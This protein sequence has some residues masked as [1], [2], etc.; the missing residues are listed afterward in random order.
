M[1]TAC[2]CL[3]VWHLHQMS[4]YW[5]SWSEI[6]D[7]KMTMGKDEGLIVS[8]VDTCMLYVDHTQH[9]CM[10]RRWAFIDCKVTSQGHWPMWA[11]E[12]ILH[13]VK[14]RLSLALW[15]LDSGCCVF[16]N[17]FLSIIGLRKLWL[18]IRWRGILTGDLSLTTC[19]VGQ[20]VG[21]RFRRT[22]RMFGSSFI[23]E[24][25]W[26]QKGEAAVA[27]WLSSCLAEQ[28]VRG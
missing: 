26:R 9:M 6:F 1:F 12:K 21:F 24:L 4:P 28:E 16:Y 14:P 5:F 15:I 27:K 20:S 22:F 10:R 11:W 7:V 3:A 19:I 13:F 17:Y 25:F 8:T 18:G 2:R 23:W